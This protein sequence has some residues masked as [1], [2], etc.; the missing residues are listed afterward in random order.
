[1]NNM[2]KNHEQYYS[3]L[4]M[5]LRGR[6]LPEARV[7]SILTEVAEGVRESGN[8]PQDEFGTPEEY[9][10]KFPKGST[11]HL[12]WWVVRILGL[13]VGVAMGIVFALSRQ[14]DL[15]NPVLF[16][17]SAW[18]YPLAAVAVLLL[19]GGTVETRLPRGFA[20]PSDAT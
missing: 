15:A 20:A 7:A 2:N 19:V 14:Q 4:A 12:G 9:A 3:Q 1:M 5:H 18:W 16:G 6:R 10:E 8:A 17:M 13:H 11:R